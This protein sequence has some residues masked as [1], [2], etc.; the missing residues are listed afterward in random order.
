MA[1]GRV[2][3]TARIAAMTTELRKLG[4]TEE[5]GRDY[6][7]ITPAPSGTTSPSTPTA[8]AAWR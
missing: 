5:E 8:I 2:K 1:N 3:E 7:S 6:L 4:A